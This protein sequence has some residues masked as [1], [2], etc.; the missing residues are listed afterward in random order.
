MRE[1]R[2]CLTLSSK[3]LLF[4]C[5]LVLVLLGGCDGPSKHTWGNLDPR[6]RAPAVPI[7]VT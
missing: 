6:A 5:L 1:R 4:L 3:R 2:S 7:A